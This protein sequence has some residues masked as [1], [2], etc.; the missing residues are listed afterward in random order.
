MQFVPLHRT[1]NKRDFWLNRKVVSFPVQKPNK[2]GCDILTWAESWVKGCQIASKQFGHGNLSFQATTWRQLSLSPETWI[3]VDVCKSPDQQGFIVPRV[4]CLLSSGIFLLWDFV[5]LPPTKG[6]SNCF[7]L[8]CDI[9]ADVSQLKQK[10]FFISE[11]K[12]N[13]H[14]H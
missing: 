14:V 3:Q 9:S 2:V 4:A 13:M 10:S 11:K 5:R 7:P 6:I 1:L 12:K 8:W